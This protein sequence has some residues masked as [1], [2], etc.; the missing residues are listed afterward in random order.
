[1]YHHKQQRA[2]YYMYISN[3]TSTILLINSTTRDSYRPFS[4][5]NR[6]NCKTLDP[7]KTNTKNAKTTGPTVK[8]SRSFAFALISTKPLL[9]TFLL[10]F[11]CFAALT[12]FDAP[13]YVST[14]SSDAVC[15]ACVVKIV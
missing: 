11:S 4:L 5:M 14:T 7:I 2:V 12:L 8:L 6:M 9:W 1:M 10:N 15:C 3:T 13:A